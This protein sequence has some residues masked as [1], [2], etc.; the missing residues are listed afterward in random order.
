M[1]CFSLKKNISFKK[2]YDNLKKSNIFLD[3]LDFKIE[4]VDNYK[5][6]KNIDENFISKN[7]LKFINTQEGS[8]YEVKS[9][10][11]NRKVN[12]NIIDYKD[13]NKNI[14]NKNIRQFLKMILF[15]INFLS[16]YSSSNCSKIINITIFLTPF[17][18]LLNN[19]QILGVNEVNTGY[20]TCGCNNIANIVIYRE[21]EW[22]KVLIHELFHNLN[23]DFCDYDIKESKRKL[24][25]NLK[26]QAKFNIYECYCETNARF[27]NILI[28][29]FFNNFNIVSYKQFKENFKINFEKEVEN[30]LLKAGLIISKI[31]NIKSYKEDSNVF[32]YYVITAALLYNFNNY[33]QFIN[34]D[35]NFKKTQENINNF[36]NLIIN[37]FN[38]NFFKAIECVG[39]TRSKS[40]KMTITNI[41]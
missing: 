10:I 3:N 22:F 21:E 15:I 29:S 28:Y 18:K 30:S 20:S 4:R 9:Q 26:I 27:I 31:K 5:N 16:L 1:S 2:F 24:R 32:D 8:L 40:L 13:S 37:S 34:Y 35:F 6:T 36:T 7:I 12:I 33:I 11:Q 25:E 41:F 23:L 19:K 39:Y 14:V 38:Y 17:K